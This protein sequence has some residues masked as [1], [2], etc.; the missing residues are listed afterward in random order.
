MPTSET[1]TQGCLLA[2]LA[3]LGAA[4]VCAATPLASAYS[5]ALGEG[6]SAVPLP[7]Y[8]PQR[9][10]RTPDR[11]PERVDLANQTFE[12]LTGTQ[13]PW[14]VAVPPKGVFETW[15]G[16]PEPEHASAVRFTVLLK[17][18][19]GERAVL[20]EEK[21]DRPFSDWKQARVDLSAWAA[22]EVILHLAV[23]GGPGCWGAPVVYSA[24]FN[25]ACIP[26]ILISNDAL[27]ADH[28]SCYGY[29]RNT[30]P[31]LDD[32]AKECVLFERAYTPESWTLT[33]HVSMM[34]GLHPRTHGVTAEL[35]LAEGYTTLGEALTQA[36]YL[37]AAFTGHGIWLAPWRGSGHG[38]DLYNRPP[39]IE[40][41]YRYRDIFDTLREAKRWVEEHRDTTF[42]LFFHNYDI[43]ATPDQPGFELPYEVRRA[44]DFRHFSAAFNPPPRLARPD[45]GRLKGRTFLEAHNAGEI[46]AAEEE[47]A[48]IM[49]LYDDCIRVVDRELHRFFEKLKALDLYDRALIIVTADHGESFN[50]HG[51]FEHADMYDSSAHVPLLIR[52]PQG[53]HA[54]LRVTEMAELQDILPT[55]LTLLGVP[56]PKEVEG[57][58]LLAALEGKGLSRD[59]VY[60]QREAF[61]TIRD[62]RWKLVTNTAGERTELYD[63][64]ADPEECK[65]HASKQS[66]KTQALRTLLDR[67]FT[68]KREPLYVPSVATPLTTEEEAQLKALGYLND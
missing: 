8:G 12:G 32:F 1:R 43:H 63:V 36:G 51:L 11:A 50:E 41:R 28:L 4:T 60:G 17:T 20:V 39:L 64:L 19:N 21:L 18:A 62:V 49:A 27:R 31:Y 54:G 14:R 26:V 10:A 48:Y 67:F 22:Q 55:V 35:D 53:R 37:A 5:A 33:A 52:F 24:A 9:L 6:D 61:R 56:L 58:S 40:E 34:T 16:V 42:F 29:E 68:T 66:H 7:A 47:T 38:F 13:P 2:F 15:M 45:R 23:D 30:T 59:Y 65:N 3:V 44:P 25:P 57:C 46:R